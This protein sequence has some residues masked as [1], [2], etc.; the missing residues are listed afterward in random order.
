MMTS[1]MTLDELWNMLQATS[2]RQQQAFG[3]HIADDGMPVWDGEDV[4]DD[5]TSES[6]AKEQFP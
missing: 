4:A 5:Y 2:R 6:Y 3:Y 1:K